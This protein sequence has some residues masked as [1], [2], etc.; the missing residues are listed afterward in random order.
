M[1]FI[2]SIVRRFLLA[3]AVFFSIIGT[4]ILGTV[5]VIIG[6]PVLKVKTLALVNPGES[7][8]MKD[9][10]K[11]LRHAGK[12]DTL[13]HVFVP[14]DSISI[15]LQNAVLAAEDDAF[16]VHPGIDI[17]ALLDAYNYNLERRRIKRGASTLTQQ[18]AKNL[19]LNGDRTFNRK[20]KELMYTMLME[21]FLGKKRI[22]ELYLNY[23]QWGKTTFGCEAASRQYFGKKSKNLS[24]HEAA[25]LA[26]VLVAPARLS[27]V[28][29]SSGFMQRRLA[30]IAANLYSHSSISAESYRDI[31]NSEPPVPD[32][33]EILPE[34]DSTIEAS[35]PLLHTETAPAESVRRDSL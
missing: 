7:A 11:I 22:L 8:F 9:Y 27:P 30:V 33:N 16:Y 18:L 24:T 28:N 14:I 23:A 13:S 15:N 35:E 31:T 10:K 20:Y 3:Y 2:L 19:F 25:R 21:N 1:K 12:A 17:N 34:A 6:I 26:A 29:A 32:S 4:V 5:A